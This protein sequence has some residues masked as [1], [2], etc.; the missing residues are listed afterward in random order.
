MKAKYYLKVSKAA[1]LEKKNERVFYRLL[2]MF[3]GLLSW[4]TIIGAFVLSYFKPLWVAIFIIVF[5]L[6]W[7]AKAFYFSFYLRASYKRLKE[8]QKEK[9]LENLKNLSPDKYNLPIQNWKE[10]YHLIVLPM[11]NESLEVVKDAF[12]SL[13]KCNY[14]KD[15]MIVVLAIEERAGEKARKV[16]EAIQKDYGDKFFRFLVTVHPKN[17]PGEI[18][19]KSSN[20]SWASKKAKLL[21]DELKIPYEKVIYS[22]FDID[23]VVYPEYFACLTYRYLTTEKPLRTS[24]QPIPLFLNNIWQVPSISRVFALS[25]SFWHIINQ[26]REEKLV[27]FSSHSM[28]FKAL[29]DVG[30]KMPNVVSDDSRI[31]WQCFLYYDGDYYVKPLFYPIS[32]DANLAETFWKTL[33]HIYKQQ[34]R[35]AYGAGEV[36]YA[37]FGFIKNKKIPLRKKISFASELIEGHWNWACGSIIL[38]FLGWLPTV[39]GGYAFSQTLF[40]YNLPRIV[41]RILTIAMIGLFSSAYYTFY[42]LPPKSREKK[43]RFNTFFVI[44]EWLTLPFTM[45]FFTSLPALDAQT[46][47]LFGKYM[48]FW[49]TPKIRKN[50]DN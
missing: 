5:A 48:G 41:G 46:R 24:F 1:D 26:E 27:T 8:S 6:Y 42:I 3:P 31:F 37:I 33:K 49:V 15:K 40:A 11:Y 22:S 12:D 43:R 20:E 50:N 47:W 23:T 30:F 29:V 21:I 44:F 13:T 4:T 19:A 7:V 9:W 17:L 36:P 2:E 38:L 45:V 14:P 10:I 34:R 35:W 25:T 16:A 28:P 39:L 18:P 32:M